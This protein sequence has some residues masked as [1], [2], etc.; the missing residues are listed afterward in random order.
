MKTLPFTIQ[1]FVF[2]DDPSL[3]SASVYPE[4]LKAQK[5]YLVQLV[6]VKYGYNAR[7]A[8]PGYLVLSTAPPSIEDAKESAEEDS[9][10]ANAALDEMAD[11]IY[12]IYTTRDKAPEVVITVHGYNTNLDSVQ[13]WYRRI[14]KYVNESGAISGQG[15]QVFIGYRWPSEQVKLKRFFKAI[16]ALPLLPFYLL[17]LGLISSA[18][19]IALEF[20]S[21]DKTVLGFALSLVPAIFV[22]LASLIFSLVVLRLIVYFRDNYRATNFG[23]PDL[24]ELMRLLDQALVERTQRNILQNN[25]SLSPEQAKEQALKFWQNDA[26]KKVNLSFIG[27]SMGGF[28]VTN[29]VR[30]LSDVFDTRSIAQEPPSDIGSVFC[31]QRLV[32]ASPD[33]PVLTIVSSRA[34]FLASS[35]RRFAESHLFSNEGDIALRLASTAANYIAFPSKTQERGY[36]LGNVAIKPDRKNR[37]NYGF[38]NLDD[39][40]Q[41]L[42]YGVDLEDAISRCQEKV[43]DNLFLS[44]QR[45]SNQCITLAK[46]FEEQQ[47]NAGQPSKAK[48]SVANFFTFFD[49][50]DYKDYTLSLPI[51]YPSPPNPRSTKA[52]GV[53]TRAKAKGPLSTLDYALLTWDYATNARDVHGGYFQGEFSQQLLYGIAFL[54]FKGYLESLHSDPSH[55]FDPHAVLSQLHEQFKQK[56]IQGFLSPMRYRVDIQGQHVKEAK[57]DM[58]KATNEEVPQASTEATIPPA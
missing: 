22:F 34:N 5:D 32:L 28:V 18:I 39:L 2:R 24:V 42:A 3:S 26:K 52:A 7:A 20:S 56:G 6:N 58:L 43:M 46:L 1:K 11:H 4:Y 37:Q 47:S 27:H 55:A 9:L 49:C 29:A 31:L 17:I 36:R 10:N 40:N 25:P 38:V 13:D 19:L 57:K 21:L 30:I 54:G 16:K 48:A 23:V 8:I 33:I 15:N 35:L 45:F 44:R 50:T 53:L 51:K 41:F 14:F 12:E